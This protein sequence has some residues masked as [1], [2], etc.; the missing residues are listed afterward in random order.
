MFGTA[1]D[2]YGVRP[3]CAYPGAGVSGQAPVS[4]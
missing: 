2:A 3:R 4:L 1:N